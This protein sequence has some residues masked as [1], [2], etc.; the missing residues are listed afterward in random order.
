MRTE[1]P[2]LDL[3]F[4]ELQTAFRSPAIEVEE[5]SDDV[6]NYVMMS[7]VVA[8]EFHSPLSQITVF[9]HLLEL[10]EAAVPNQV[11]Q[12]QIRYRNF[13]PADFQIQ[14][15]KAVL[16]I[17]SEKSGYAVA[18]NFDLAKILLLPAFFDLLVDVQL[19]VAL[20][21]LPDIF[22]VVKGDVAYPRVAN[23]AARTASRRVA[24]FAELFW[25]VVDPAL[26]GLIGLVNCSIEALLWSFDGEGGA[27]GGSGGAGG[28]VPTAVGDSRIGGRARWQHT[29]I[30]R[31]N[32]GLRELDSG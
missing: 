20:V 10:G 5:R 26:L 21:W 22:K 17:V 31:L 9:N 30:R 23:H 24:L 29:F 3:V 11:R 2:N 19:Q 32:W 6:E 28:F 25:R 16:E 15:L 4:L 13:P 1:Q 8:A 7:C 27:V 14:R 18:L 12:L